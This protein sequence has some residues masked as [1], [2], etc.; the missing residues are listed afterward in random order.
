M[1]R[2]LRALD[3]PSAVIDTSVR[4]HKDLRELSSTMG[5]RYIPLP[6]ADARKL[7]RAID[8]A[9]GG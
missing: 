8:T 9:L 1:A 5:A 6:R 2:H 7:S 3:L 4:P